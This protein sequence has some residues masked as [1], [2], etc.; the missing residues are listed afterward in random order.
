MPSNDATMVIELPQVNHIPN[1]PLELKKEEEEEKSECE[2][3]ITENANEEKQELTRQS[4]EVDYISGDTASESEE[5]CV[6]ESMTD[7]ITKAKR[8]RKQ[9]QDKNIDTEKIT[10]ISANELEKFSVLLFELAQKLKSSGR[11]KLCP[12]HKFVEGKSKLFCEYCGITM[13]I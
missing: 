8:R 12:P 10:R 7:G 5:T 13:N 6:T 2:S 4:S 11:E 9:T 1:I 3:N